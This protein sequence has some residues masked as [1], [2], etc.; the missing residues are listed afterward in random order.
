[1]AAGLAW[2]LWM[3]TIGRLFAAVRGPRARGFDLI[4]RA[5]RP[6]RPRPR[7]RA[8]PAVEGR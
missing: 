7:R 4:A 2:T 5:R 6:R 8:T 1:M 3:A